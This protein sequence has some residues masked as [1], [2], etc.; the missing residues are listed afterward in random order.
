MKAL[1]CT[2]STEGAPQNS[3]CRYLCLQGGL[4][5]LLAR[6]ARESWGLRS[7]HCRAQETSPR[8]ASHA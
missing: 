2:V 4:Q 1:A 6:V 3:Y 8:Q 5:V 7:S